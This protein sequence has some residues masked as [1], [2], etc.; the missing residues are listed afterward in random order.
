[1]RIAV[2]A[3]VHGNLYAFEAALAHVR[4]QGV[5]QVV[6]L[7][8]LTVG[9]PDAAACWQ[10]A[11]SLE[12]PSIWGNHERYVAY[13]GTAEADPRWQGEQYAPVAW[14]VSQLSPVERRAMRALPYC[15]RTPDAPDVLFCHASMR[16]DRDTVAAHTPGDRLCEMYPHVT[17]SFIVRGHNHLG[18]VR[19]WDG[20]T[21]VTVGSVGL[22]LDSYPTAQYLMLEHEGGGWQITHHSVPYDVDAAVRRFE[23]TGYLDAV[24]PMGRLFQREV[25]TAS[26]QIV[27]FLRAYARWSSE[28]HISLAGAVARYLGTSG[29]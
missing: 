8:D 6:L 25:A 23:E 10:L 16:S 7:G 5:D 27:P 4:G 22:P 17:E 26:H 24:G 19:F 2:L 15:Y 14:A 18:Q 13:Y 28:E 11:R 12:C 21:V 9:S 3:D 20:H 1:V 29:R